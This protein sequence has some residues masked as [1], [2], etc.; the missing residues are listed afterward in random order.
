MSLMSL[1]SGFCGNDFKSEILNLPIKLGEKQIPVKDILKNNKIIKLEIKSDQKK[2]NNISS[3]TNSLTIS[4]TIL[5]KNISGLEPLYYNAVKVNVLILFQ[6]MI[7][8]DEKLNLNCKT[9]LN[10]YNK[11]RDI[12]VEC[13]CLSLFN[14]LENNDKINITKLIGVNLNEINL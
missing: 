7:M 12:T 4:F 11:G 10:I 5:G 3:G 6:Q 1:I 8:G 13:N 9:V 2:E 14:E